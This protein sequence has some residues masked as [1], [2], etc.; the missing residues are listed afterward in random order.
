LIYFADFVGVNICIAH[1]EHENALNVI[2]SKAGM[3][4]SFKKSG[5]RLKPVPEGSNRGDSRN[6]NFES[7]V[8]SMTK[9]KTIIMQ[10]SII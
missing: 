2:P 9:Q 6:D 8:G 4:E 7:S 3:T 10:H 5:F 1:K